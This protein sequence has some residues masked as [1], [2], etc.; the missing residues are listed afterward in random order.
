MSQIFDAL[1]RS[2]SERKGTRLSGLPNATELLE[3]AERH[4]AVGWD[5]SVEAS[6][7]I[8]NGNGVGAGV[9]LWEAGTATA[10]GSSAARDLLVA[11]HVSGIFPEFQT[12]PR[13]AS[14]PDRLVC[15]SDEESPG[16]EA[17]RFLGV[18]L[19][20]LRRDRTL[21]KVLITSTIPQ[22]GKT[23][24]IAN[25]GCALAQRTTQKV[26]LLD[27]DLR[28]PALTQML[29][30][31]EKPG[32]CEWLQE[33][34][35]LTSC[36]YSREGMGFWM[37]PSGRTSSSS[38]ELLQAAKIGT[39]I[40]T[41]SQWF[42]WILIDSPPILPL[43]DTSVWARLADGILLVTRQ[44]VT[45]KKHLQKG[46]DAIEPQKLIGAVLNSCD[47]PAHGDYYYSRR[48]QPKADELS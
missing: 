22:E 32:I 7:S 17:F 26:L 35:A 8:D 46:L 42:D 43:A 1:Q 20:H 19:R 13:L 47:K 10:T 30:L 3:S 31:E 29:G 15:L 34:K 36:I 16:A 4:A 6:P 5:G 14:I 2:E 18:R 40:D 9:E 27:G 39:L 41:L 23:T 48:D 45:E 38:A 21:K 11:D 44:G 25:L 24:V 33:Q 37:M 12:L 28:R